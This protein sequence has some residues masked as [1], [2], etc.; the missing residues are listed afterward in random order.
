M[1]TVEIVDPEVGV[2]VDPHENEGG[3][4]PLS[5]NFGIPSRNTSRGVRAIADVNSQLMREL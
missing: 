2:V 3:G 5:A 4:R 1:V